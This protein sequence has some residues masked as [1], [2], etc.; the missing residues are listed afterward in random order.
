M[1]CLNR[2]IMNSRGLHALRRCYQQDSLLEIEQH[3]CEDHWPVKLRGREDR[4]FNGA[5][6]DGERKQKRFLMFSI[7]VT[8]YLHRI[9]W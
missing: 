3:Q 8:Y 1:V 9:N 6:P 7:F 2:L 4:L 5:E